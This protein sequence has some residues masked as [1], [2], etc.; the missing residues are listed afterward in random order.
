MYIYRSLKVG[1]CPRTLLRPRRGPAGALLRLLRLFWHSR[2]SWIVGA[3]SFGSIPIRFSS[4]HVRL[5]NNEHHNIIPVFLC[6][7]CAL[8][9][10]QYYKVQG[11]ILSW[12]GMTSMSKLKIVIHCPANFIE[13]VGLG[14]FKNTV[15]YPWPSSM[16]LMKLN[17]IPTFLRHP[18]TF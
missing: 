4:R 17:T 1:W 18:F 16:M 12:A 6:N 15:L 2:S 14:Q 3:W 8:H 5:T 11:F 10:W 7:R 9:K 13:F